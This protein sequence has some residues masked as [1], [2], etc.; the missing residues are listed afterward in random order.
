MTPDEIAALQ[1]LNAVST[2][3][4][5]AFT[6]KYPTLR[7]NPGEHIAA[8]TNING[9]PTFVSNLGGVFT[10]GAFYG[11]A[12]NDG[13]ANP[14]DPFI[15]ISPNGSGGYVLLRGSGAKYPFGPGANAQPQPP[16]TVPVDT[17][18]TQDPG[19]KNAYGEGGP[20]PPSSQI[21]DPAYLELLRSLDYADTTARTNETVTEGDLAQAAAL[22]RSQLGLAGE[23]ALRDYATSA[24]DRNVLR[25]GEYSLGNARQTAL[26]QSALGQLDLDTSQQIGGLQRTLAQQLADTARQRAEAALRYAAGQRTKTGTTEAGLGAGYQ[27]PPSAAEPAPTFTI[28]AYNPPAAVVAPK[29]AA[30]KPVVATK[31]ALTPL[32]GKF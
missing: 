15:G 12:I 28:P 24:E 31:P 25:S 9:Q 18:P 26:N 19:S 7:L 21:T 17:E 1:Y 20:N 16:P 13:T 22:H 11:S 29:P 2:Q 4:Q 5:A 14:A 32:K 23:K 8:M 30:P 6:A 27:P 10:D 3:A